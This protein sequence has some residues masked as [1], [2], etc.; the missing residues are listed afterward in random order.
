MITY[1]KKTC[2]RCGKK[3]IC[4][5]VIETYYNKVYRSRWDRKDLKFVRKHRRRL[6]CRSCRT[7][8]LGDKPIIIIRGKDGTMAK[9][10]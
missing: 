4:L 3:G 1:W 8:I 5:K 9:M 6:L 2:Q 7:T 10:E